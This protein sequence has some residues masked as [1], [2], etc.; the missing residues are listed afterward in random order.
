MQTRTSQRKKQDLDI[1]FQEYEENPS[2]PRH[3][4]YIA[5]TYLCMHDYENA[6]KYYERRVSYVK[7]ESGFSQEIQD[8]LYKMGVISYFDMNNEWETV[9]LQLFLNCYEFDKTRSEALYIIGYYYSTSNALEASNKAYY[10]LKKALE[11]SRQYRPSTMNSKHKINNYDIPK[12]LLTYCYIFNDYEIGI[13]CSRKCIEHHETYEPNTQHNFNLWLSIFLLCDSYMKYPKILPTISD[14][15]KTVCFVAPGGWDKWDGETLSKKGLGG[16]ETWVIR[17]A[18]YIKKLYGSS[19]KSIIFCNCEK[20]KIYNDVSYINLS[21]FTE[22][23]S[24]NVIDYCFVSR[25][26]EYIPVCIKSSIKNIY[27]VFHDLLRYNEIIPLSD[28]I[29]GII[30]LTEWHKKYIANHFPQFEHNISVMSYGIDIPQTITENVCKIPYSFI[31]PSFPHRGLVQLLEMFP[32]IKGK[33]KNASL[34]VFCNLELE[35]S[36]TNT[37]KDICRVNELIKQPGVIN[38]GWVSEGVL[39]QFWNISQVWFYPTFFRETYCRIALEAAMSKTLCITS[40]VAA[41]NENV[42]DR[43][44]IISGD[45]TTEEWQNRALDKLDHILN[46]KVDQDILIEKN[47]KWACDRSYNN[48]VE[49]FNDKYLC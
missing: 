16:S 19:Y 38:H 6:Y 31:Y 9:C 14:S 2:N 23:I 26:T 4:Y 15:L 37:N 5:E 47:Y 8:S 27:V 18:E 36:K 46:S 34:N 21:E 45:P 10:Y 32:K 17:F 33:Y 30:C 43:G 48:V 20:N 44:I 13:E 11:V 12:L 39:R 25:Y 1:L 7:E 49:S 41:L 29:R 35:W 42:G 28:S 3:S 40:D 24:K 22:Y